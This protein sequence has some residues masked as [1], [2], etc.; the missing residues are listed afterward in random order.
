M[1]GSPGKKKRGTAGFSLLELIIT[2]AAG[3]LVILGV[4]R[5]LISSLWSY[6]LQEQMTDMYQNATYTIKRIGDALAQVGLDL[7]EKYFNVV[8]VSAS[9]TSSVLM[10]V[11]K[12]GGKWVC[13]KDTTTDKI[14]VYPDS[15]GLT[16]VGADS[17][18]VDTGGWKTS[19]KITNVKTGLAAD[20][21]VLGTSTLFKTY[22]VV[23]RCDTARYFINGTNFCVDTATNIQAEN[24]DSL[25]MTFRD[26]SNSPTTSWTSMVSVQIYVR[27]RT[28]A[29]D[30][31]YRDP[32]YSDGYHRL[33]LTMNL[34]LRNKF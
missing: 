27:A 14:V 25:S 12:K 9:P 10:K 3:S 4:Y 24:I 33:A 30:P 18:V 28:S 21:I 22:N 5:L 6:N 19:V 29:P 20:T 26:A 23:Y 7:P 32:V 34:R 15:V 31:R 17:V 2:I 16:F 13:L 1:T 11:N 8:Y